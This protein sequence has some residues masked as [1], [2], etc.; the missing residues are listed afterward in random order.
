MLDCAYS[1]I[2]CIL[3]MWCG[4]EMP[5]S[6]DVEVISVMQQICEVFM[7]FLLWLA[8]CPITELTNFCDLT[9]FFLNELVSD[10]VLK[11]KDSINRPFYEILK[12]T[13]DFLWLINLKTLHWTYSLL[14]SQLVASVFLLSITI[15]TLQN[16]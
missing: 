13:C 1:A 15:F 3:A 5:F 12:C 11:C 6:W 14:T 10:S 9:Q 16:E 8:G 7:I 2:T 4:K